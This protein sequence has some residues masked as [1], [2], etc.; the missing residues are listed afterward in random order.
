MP[1]LRSS[2]R[3]LPRTPL[4][5]AVAFRCTTVNH[6]RFYMFALS[7][8]QPTI[9]LVAS[10]A[11]HRKNALQSFLIFSMLTR[12]LDRRRLHWPVDREF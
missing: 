7:L 10:T 1:T 12:A 5:L 4:A 8:S 3:S 6:S 11:I 9:V 2:R